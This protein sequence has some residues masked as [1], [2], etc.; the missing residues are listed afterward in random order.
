MF[1]LNE[2]EYAEKCLRDGIIDR[3]P[4]QVIS[5]LAKYYY[6]HCGFKRKQIVDLLIDYLKKYYTRYEL[7]EDQW[8]LAIEKLATNAQKEKLYEFSGVKIT[9]NEINTIKNIKNKS[10]EKLAF[11]SLCL[12]K[13]NNLKNPCNNGWVN[14]ETGDIF[15]AAHISCS[16]FEQDVKLNKLYLLGLVEFPKK[17]DNLNYR[18]T[19]IDNDGDEELFISDFRELG[20]EYLNYLGED[21]IRCGECGI[22]TRPSENNQKKYCEKHKSKKEKQIEKIIFCIDCGD[23][24]EVASKDN[25]TNRC[26]KCYEV[27]RKECIRKN[28]QKLREKQKCNQHKIDSNTYT[29]NNPSI[30]EC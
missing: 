18:I 21:F 25:Q 19:F 8:M 1:I 20:Y 15:K 7:N 14:T 23:P 2:K 26:Y 30:I 28:V 10:L 5:I 6:H 29:P 9:E 13:L 24:I 12:A 27:Y 17:N 16:V 22:L 3:N 11:T 4:Y